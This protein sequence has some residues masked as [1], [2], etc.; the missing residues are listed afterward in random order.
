MVVAAY[1]EAQLIGAT[2][3]ALALAFSGAQLWVAD[4]GS[5]DGLTGNNVDFPASSPFALAC[6]GTKLELN[7]SKSIVREV[8]WNELASGSGATG[9]GFS[10]VFNL[11][12]YQ[13]NS[14]AKSSQFRGV[15]DVSGDADPLTGYRV[16]VDGAP[17]VIGGTSAVAPLWAGLLARLVQA[18]GQPFGLIQP[19]L[20]AGVSPGVAVA[21]FRDITSGNNGSYSAGPGWDAC[22]GLGSPAG[23][24]LL[25]RLTG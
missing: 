4:D 17:E 3:Q 16:L 25:D 20:Y 9:G 11:P 1:N 19:A 10:T 24:A 8:V 18:T 7:A 13:K 22:T 12:E 14:N 6:G 21:G 2:L 15:P 5:S 23:T